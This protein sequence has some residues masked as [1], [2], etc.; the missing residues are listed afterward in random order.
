MPVQIGLAAT[1][2]SIFGYSLSL[3]RLTTLALTIVLL[4][5]FRRLLIDRGSSPADAFALSLC[6]FASPV[7]LMLSFTFMS[8]VQFLA[9]LVLALMLYT[10]ASLSGSILMMLTGSFA[11]ACAI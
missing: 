4:V 7:L 9:W 3:L 1:M 5:S 8:D 10:R 6:L 2:A 11:A